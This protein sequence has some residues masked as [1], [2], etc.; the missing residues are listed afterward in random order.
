M[1]YRIGHRPVAPSVYLIT[2]GG[3]LDMKAS[4]KLRR[5]IDHALENE[6]SLLVV[7]LTDATFI[8]S[9]GIGALV[10]ALKRL[11]TEGGSLE[12]A[13]SEPN[14]LRIFELTGLDRL[15]SIH[16]SRREALGAF[17]GASA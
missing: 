5:T 11:T 2:V 6:I 14:L 16:P 15:L 7:D 13:C 3:E 10:A 9:T 8:D 12:I 4:P 1:G 17:A